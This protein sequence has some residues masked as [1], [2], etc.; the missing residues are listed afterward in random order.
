MDGRASEAIAALPLRVACLAPA[1]VLAGADSG[2]N[3]LGGPPFFRQGIEWF[4]PRLVRHEHAHRSRLRRAFAYSAVATIAPDLF[5]RNGLVPE[6]YFEAA[7]FILAFILAGNA[8]EG[9]AKRKTSESLRALAALQPDRARIERAGSELEVD[10]DQ[11]LPGDLLVVRPGE[12]IPADG[13][14]VQGESAVDESMLTGEPVPVEKGAGGT[15]TG[16][17]LNGQGILRIRVEAAGS[18][19][20]LERILRLLREAQTE[21]APL[22][23]LADRVS[24][25]FVPAVMVI[26]TVAGVSWLWLDG[27]P[28]RAVSAAVAVLII[29]CPCAMGLATPAAFLAATGRAA[30]EGILLRGGEG[31]ERL[32]AVDTVV[33]DKTGTLTEGKPVVDEVRPEPEWTAEEALRLAASLEFASEHPLPARLW[34]GPGW[35]ER[36]CRQ[37]THSARSP[38]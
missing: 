23:K 37:W 18:E 4:T 11:L 33:F 38:G 30:K 9:R 34:N 36:R 2:H 27:N 35:K 6:V 22:Q 28:A 7:V 3:G 12:R 17:T 21:K 1:L 16:G 31:L 8:L 32:A 26:A 15:V 25:V 20:V 24:A 19:T 29:A 5:L 14:V 10:I 13:T